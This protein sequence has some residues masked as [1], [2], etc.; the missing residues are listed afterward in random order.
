MA[1]E[2]HHKAARDCDK[3]IQCL[4]ANARIA[5]LDANKARI[6]D[7]EA[8]KENVK[9]QE[10]AMREEAEG[11]RPQKSFSRK[12]KGSL[13]A[14]YTRSQAL[15]LTQVLACLIQGNPTQMNNDCPD[16]NPNYCEMSC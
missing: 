3:C 16:A 2:F 15:G 7:E 4:T 5:E 6:N 10:T 11:L 12:T 13:N 14:T 9:E 8:A 1:K